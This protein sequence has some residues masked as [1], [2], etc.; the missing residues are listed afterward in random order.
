LALD[1]QDF[2]G[3]GDEGGP[4]DVQ[5]LFLRPKVPLHGGGRRKVAAASVPTFW[6]T[7][8]PPSK[9]DVKLVSFILI[10]TKVVGLCCFFLCFFWFFFL[11]VV[12]EMITILTSLLD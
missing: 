5:R 10:P 12:R 7:G 4:L 3:R 8:S 6:K 11:F 2:G 9:S 1:E